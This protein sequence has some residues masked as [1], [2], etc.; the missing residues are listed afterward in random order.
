MSEPTPRTGDWRLVAPAWSWDPSGTTA[1]R[2]TMPI[3]QKYES[4]NFVTDFVAGSTERIVVPLFARIQDDRLHQHKAIF[5]AIRDRA[6]ELAR[7]RMA[8]L[9]RDSIGDVREYLRQRGDA[10]DATAAG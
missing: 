4:S 3:L 1:P 6:P 10:T 5:E 9:L 7:Q 8:E 2:T